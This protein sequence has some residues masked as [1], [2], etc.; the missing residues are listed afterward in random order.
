MSTADLGSADV[1]VIGGGLVGTAT[2]YYLAKGGVDVALL[3]RN[4]AINREASG[5]NAGSLHLQIYLHS[6]LPPDWRQRVAP[7]VVMLREAAKLWATVETEL[8][9]DCGVRLG[10]G[11]WVAETEEEMVRVR[12]KV[13][14]ENEYGVMSEVLNRN[15]ILSV[16]P[17]LGPHI[18]GG[19][20]L[21]GEGFANPLLTTP[22]YA[23]SA[24]KHGARIV[25]DAEI[26][27]IE[28]ERDGRFSLNTPRGIFRARRVVASAGAWTSEIARMVGLTLPITGVVVQVGVTEGRPSIM[29]DQLVQHVSRGLTLKQW[30]QGGFVIGG[31]WP[32]LY[33]RDTRKKSPA[34]DSLIGNMAVLMRTVPESA[35]AQLVRSW[36]GVGT[37]T[38][39]GLAVIGE[40]DRVKGFYVSWAPLGFTM[41][42]ITGKL[43]A[44]HFLGRESTLPIDNYS[45]N[46]F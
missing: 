18:I 17:Y 33:D 29:L 11:L 28:R 7:G 40:S 46:R 38:Q 3:E 37:G 10:G 35:G 43:F 15:E 2:T 8:G 20:F 34:L 31:G 16:A 1:A 4:A 13:R 42:P 19:S 22:A 6:H 45:P 36:A 23:R 27:S 44:E 32:G 5:V 41:G 12:D 21:K 26:K 14:I 24:K 39:D 9:Q 30:P 25:T